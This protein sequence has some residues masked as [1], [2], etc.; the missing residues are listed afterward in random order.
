V[1]TCGFCIHLSN[2]LL[3]GGKHPTERQI[4]GMYKTWLDKGHIVALVIGET[5]QGFVK[6]V[7]EIDCCHFS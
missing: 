1:F 4:I 6:G 5:R 7:N 3:E 2:T